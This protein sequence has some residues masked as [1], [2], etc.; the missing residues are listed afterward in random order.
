MSIDKFSQCPCGSGK[1]VKF[2]CSKDLLHEFES[3]FRMIDGDQRLAAIQYANRTLE[4]HPNVPSLVAVKA[5]L[6]LQLKQWPEALAAA[7]RLKQLSPE[8]SRPYA[9]LAIAAVSENEPAKAV[10]L[11]QDSVDR[12]TDN[13][14]DSY[15]LN[16]F[17]MIGVLLQSHGDFVAAR[18]HLSYYVTIASRSDENAS[19]ALVRLDSSPEVPLIAKDS[20]LPPPPAENAP[21]LQAYR[22]AIQVLGQGRMRASVQGLRKLVE[23]YPKEPALIAN[24]ATELGWLNETEHSA[25]M[26]R[27]FTLLPD[28]D[29]ELVV[30]AEALAQVTLHQP[31]SDLVFPTRITC[32]FDNLDAV[33]E[34]LLSSP[35]VIKA[36]VDLSQIA[37]ED[38]PPPKAVFYLLT[39]EPKE[40][41]AKPLVRGDLPIVL[42]DV[43]VYGR[44][45][46]RPARLEVDVTAEVDLDQFISGL[47]EIVG[48]LS[49]VTR[50]TIEDE[51]TTWLSRN[52]Y[53][54]WYVGGP[55]EQDESKQLLQEQSREVLLDKWLR[56]PCSTLNGKSPNEAAADFNLRLRVEAMILRLE[57]DEASAL[58][59]FDFNEVRRK[60]DLPTRGPIDPAGVDV[61]R[62]PFVR[63]ERLPADKLDDEQ[64]L[65]ALRRSQLVMAIPALMNFAREAVARPSL[66]AR[67]NKFELFRLL[68]ET[69]PDSDSALRFLTQGK[70]FASA[71]NESPAP[72]LLMEMQIHM[73]RRDPES[74]Q[75]VMSQLQS[76]HLNE[77]G[78]AEALYQFL[79]MIGAVGP[80]GQLSPELSNDGPE[81]AGAA[82][83]GS[84]GGLWTPDGPAS[85]GGSGEG[86]SK[87]WLPGMD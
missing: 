51:P 48:E 43:L 62:L 39:Q 28:L 21:W 75:R 52:L 76:K 50:E 12:M 74:V 69:A 11:L 82:A 71:R 25:E 33:M 59:G 57:T 83:V 6:H 56:Q 1:K 87:L 86:G 24:L 64:L 22:D 80:D 81:A 4:T 42:G 19:Q 41:L 17:A 20:I 23:Q 10:S 47:T 30:E 38:Q 40:E 63:L 8:S 61:R 37:E 26:W 65:V 13:I 2:C 31:T 49:D 45:T 34:R 73:A 53:P 29:H 77:P 84:S 67:I 70:A 15:A 66:D 72:W 46:D 54:R 36:N 32:S 5:E 3:I 9:L 85:S 44:Q 16:A 55:L 79:Y 60:L 7:E 78:V 27:R 35:R 68:V 14:I 18:G 58:Q